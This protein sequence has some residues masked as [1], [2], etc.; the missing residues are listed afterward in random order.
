MLCFVYTLARHA[1]RQNDN[2]ETC[3]C[4]R[5]SRLLIQKPN[6]I[7]GRSPT[8]LHRLEIAAERLPQCCI[9]VHANDTHQ[10]Y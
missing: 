4:C 10:C 1:L 3:G 8:Q 5:R 9:L 6:A 7:P 2:I